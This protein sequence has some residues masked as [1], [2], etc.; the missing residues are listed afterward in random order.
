ME[1]VTGRAMAEICQKWGIDPGTLAFLGGGRGDSD[2]IVYAYP[3]ARG[4]MVL[5]ILALGEND[6]DRL[7]A[8][9]VRA[10]FARHLGE[11]GIP[12]ACPEPGADG[13]LYAESVDGG[14]RYVAVTM[15]YREGH[16]PENAELTDGFARA[17]GRL[18]GRAHRAAKSFREGDVPALNYGRELNG[19][20]EL[21]RDPDAGA[22]WREMGA[23]LAALPRTA[24]D[25]G[26]IHN[27]NHQ[28]NILADGDGIALIDFDCAM[29]QFFLHDVTTPLQGLMFEEAGGML[30]P[31]GDGARLGRFLSSFLEGYERENHLDLFWCERITQFVNYRRLLLFT[32]MQDWLDTRA[33]LKKGFLQNIRKPPEI[34]L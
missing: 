31:L 32:V 14:L 2:G 5:K 25:Y 21:C 27:D 22:A 20:A 10:R 33:E 15:A 18:T 30:S 7:A 13:S 11:S 29:R 17:W 1:A 16:T 23:F 26:F 24:D 12:V 4:K 28:R 6:A 34:W 9:E 3:S 19:F 8:L